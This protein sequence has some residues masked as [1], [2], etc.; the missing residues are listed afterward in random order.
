VRK[1]WLAIAMLVVAAGP[2]VVAATV[3]VNIAPVDRVF[4]DNEVVWHFDVFGTDLT[5]DDERLTRYEIAV[6]G[7]GTSSTGVPFGGANAAGF[8][9]PELS[10]GRVGRPTV[11]PYVF[12][13]FEPISPIE[14]FP[15]NRSNLRFGAWAIGQDDEANLDEAHN[16]FLRFELRTRKEDLGTYALAVTSVS[17]TGNGPPIIATAGVPATFSIVPEPSAAALLV[18]QALALLRRQTAAS[19]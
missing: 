3:V 10:F 18:A 11:H 19:R 12:N 9:V 17:L 1:S 14:K 15:S 4:T 7:T 2:S 5:G 8:I 13:D 16:G 6:E